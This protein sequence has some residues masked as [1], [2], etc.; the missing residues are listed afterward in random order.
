[1]FLLHSHNS[2][3][4]L[5]YL[6]NTSLS[7]KLLF[8]SLDMYSHFWIAVTVILSCTS[9]GVLFAYVCLVYINRKTICIV[10]SVSHFLL[11][12]SKL[13]NENITQLFQ[14]LINIANEKSH[15]C[16]H[17]MPSDPNIPHLKKKLYI[18]FISVPCSLRW[19]SRKSNADSWFVR[20]QYA[21]FLTT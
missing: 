8:Q 3:G 13:L 4:A 11:V 7:P 12:N 1:M 20:Y 14:L 9:Y 19:R 6:F 16:M 21:G 5:I 18:L 17:I 15:R 2:P 10:K